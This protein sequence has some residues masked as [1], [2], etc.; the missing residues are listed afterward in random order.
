M[1]LTCAARLTDPSSPGPCCYPNLCKDSGN[2]GKS[3][4]GCDRPCEDDCFDF[5]CP[6]DQICSVSSKAC[7]SNPGGG[8]ETAFARDRITYDDGVTPGNDKFCGTAFNRWGWTNGPYMPINSGRTL[9]IYAGAGQCLTTNGP[10]KVGEATVAVVA[11]VAGAGD[12]V[13]VTFTPD[14]GFKFT[15][16]H[17]QVSCDDLKYALKGATPTVAPGQ[18]TVVENTAVAS[19]VPITKTFVAGGSLPIDPP[20]GSTASSCNT[21]YWVIIHAVSCSV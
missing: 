14:T 18:Y 2:S 3:K 7:V 4:C 5:C 16:Y 13:T 1:S 8:C 6:T 20:P 12:T 10:G 9:D 11:G 17:I 15:E 21:G 19:G